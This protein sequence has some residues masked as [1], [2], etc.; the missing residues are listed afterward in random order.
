MRTYYTVIDLS[1][2]EDNAQWR[3]MACDPLEYDKLSSVD[4]INVTHAATG[5][6]HASFVEV[7]EDTLKKA[8]PILSVCSGLSD[9]NVHPTWSRYCVS[10]MEIQGTLVSHFCNSFIGRSN[11]GHQQ[12]MSIRGAK[13]AISTEVYLDDDADSFRSVADEYNTACT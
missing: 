7:L 12:P 8:E 1:S 4:T 3:K 5:N 2:I 6:T 10:C 13:W 9:V 11:N